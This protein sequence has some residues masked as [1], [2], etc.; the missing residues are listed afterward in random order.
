MKDFECIK[1]H[2]MFDFDKY[3]GVCPK[4][5]VFNP[6]REGV[7]KFCEEIYR[8]YDDVPSPPKIIVVTT[9]N[10]VKKK[11]KTPLFVLCF[12]ILAVLFMFGCVSISQR[13][14]NKAANE[15]ITLEAGESIS[16]KNRDYQI[17][18][19]Q[20][21][22]P[23]GLETFLREDEKMIGVYVKITS[24]AGSAEYSLENNLPYVKYGDD[25]YKQCLYSADVFP[26]IDNYG[27]TTEQ[28]LD[29]YTGF[30][31]SIEGYY[32]YLVDKDADVVTV[33]LER[34]E[35]HIGEEVI[36]GVYQVILPIEERETDIHE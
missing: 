17:L 18:K 3:Y 15:T 10:V 27:L 9:N 1:C 16:L 13:M 2:K 12:C 6:K 26:Y 25:F 20:E 23:A 33:T 4:C 24:K 28:V 22:I 35:K 31:D 5:G 8:K 32:I 29:S 36:T 19:A 30:Y 21:I 34:K 7:G 14:M 11:N